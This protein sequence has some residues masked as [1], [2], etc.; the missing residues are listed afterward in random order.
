VGC[1]GFAIDLAV[2]DPRRAG[3]YLLGIECD[4]ATYHSSPTARDRDRL[5]QS[6]L[7]GLGWELFRVWST[8]WFHRPAPVRERLLARLNE[9][10]EMPMD[11]PAVTTVAAAPPAVQAAALEESPA[12]PARSELLPPGVV[13]YAS[14]RDRKRSHGDTMTPDNLGAV[15][16]HIV[17]IE[18]PIHVDEAA[19][20]CAEVFGTKAT[21]RH[22]EMFDHAVA[23]ALGQKA[24]CRAGV[25]SF[26]ANR[27]RLPRFDIAGRRIVR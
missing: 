3:R 19:R 22:R 8:D 24:D 6:V 14:A 2:V 7:E 10:R 18:G 26:G 11:E 15:V 17:E 16:Q 25:R 5:R 27:R 1:A 23:V 20:A 9:L 21:A 4:G 13:A 12:A